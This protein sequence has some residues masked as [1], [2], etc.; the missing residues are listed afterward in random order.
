MIEVNEVSEHR[1]CK[2]LKKYWCYLLLFGCIAVVWCN[3][4]YEIGLIS[5]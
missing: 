3:A 5:F 4:A 2:K 1:C